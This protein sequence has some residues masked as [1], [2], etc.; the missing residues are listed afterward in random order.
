MYFSIYVCELSVCSEI[1]F[2]LN[3]SLVKWYPL[4]E[5]SFQKKNL[6]FFKLMELSIRGPYLTILMENVNFLNHQST[7]WWKIPFTFSIFFVTFPYCSNITLL[8]I[9]L[10]SMFNCQRYASTLNVKQYHQVTNLACT[11]D[12]WRPKYTDWSSCLQR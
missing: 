4:H 3:L 7:C 10:H 8:L 6:N 12:L 1:K 11:P 5:G 2:N 9:A